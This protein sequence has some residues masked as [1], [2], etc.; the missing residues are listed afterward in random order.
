MARY[1]ESPAQGRAFLQPLA[2]KQR[3][4]PKKCGQ[5]RGDTGIAVPSH[6]NRNVGAAKDATMLEDVEHPDSGKK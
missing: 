2:E 1:A 3:I 6:L 4:S 5:T